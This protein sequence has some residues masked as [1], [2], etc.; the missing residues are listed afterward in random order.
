MAKRREYL[1]KPPRD[2]SSFERPGFKGW[3]YVIV[4]AIIVATI[5]LLIYYN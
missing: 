5:G 1:Y 2:D 3:G 4:G